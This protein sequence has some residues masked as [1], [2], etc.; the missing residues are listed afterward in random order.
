MSQAVKLSHWVELDP[1]AVPSFL[2]F[3][4][5]P[6]IYSFGQSYHCI[7]APDTRLHCPL[8]KQKKMECFLCC[9]ETDSN[10]DCNALEAWC[11]IIP[12]V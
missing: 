12:H 1:P 3:Y 11:Q 2:S 4:S 9:D 6:D 10:S 7:K 8:A 5:F